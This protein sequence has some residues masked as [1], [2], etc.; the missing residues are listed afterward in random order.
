MCGLL[1][2]GVQTPTGA[3]MHAWRSSICSSNHAM[4]LWAA[5][6]VCMCL[7]VYLQ[8]LG[9]IRSGVT[10]SVLRLRVQGSC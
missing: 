6:D 2:A 9:Y 4:S 5:V 8:L 7:S 1:Q 3:T 10:P